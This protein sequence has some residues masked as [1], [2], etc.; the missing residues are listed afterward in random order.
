MSTG[1]KAPSIPPSEGGPR[2]NKPT[3]P[4]APPPLFGLDDRT[5]A[6]ALKTVGVDYG[7]PHQLAPRA[8][9]QLDRAAPIS[10]AIDLFIANV[11]RRLSQS[12]EPFTLAAVVDALSAERDQLQHAE[13]TP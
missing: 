7:V 10:L 5:L 11:Y 2:H 4:P 6:L 12:A 9:A 1:A 8:L 3:P 13:V